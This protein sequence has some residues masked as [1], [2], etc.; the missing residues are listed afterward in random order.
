MALENLFDVVFVSAHLARYLIRVAG[1]LLSGAR[2]SNIVSMIY[3]S[4]YDQKV[5][6]RSR[7]IN[8]WRQLQLQGGVGVGLCSSVL[9]GEVA[10]SP[11]RQKPMLPFGSGGRGRKAVRSG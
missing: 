6:L 3:Q 4:A 9:R 11:G 8:S 1:C 5:F 2:L 7:Y 10:Q